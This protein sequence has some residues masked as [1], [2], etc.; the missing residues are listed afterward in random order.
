MTWQD[1]LKALNDKTPDVWILFYDSGLWTC[2]DDESTTIYYAETPE[3]AIA[4]AY[5]GEIG[6]E[7]VLKPDPGS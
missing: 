7:S 1:Q 2:T 3:Q 6:K 4:K 5:E